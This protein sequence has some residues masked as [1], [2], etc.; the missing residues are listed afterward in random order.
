MIILPSSG[1]CIFHGH[2]NS[3]T[4]NNS[5]V[6][7]YHYHSTTD[8]VFVAYNILEGRNCC[9]VITMKKELHLHKS[10]NVQDAHIETG[11]SPKNW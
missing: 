11:V 5:S 9:S 4:T 1:V 10:V 3:S 2:W 7:H 8:V 6:E